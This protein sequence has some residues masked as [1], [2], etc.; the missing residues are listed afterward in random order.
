M[1]NAKVTEAVGKM[2]DKFKNAKSYDLL[3]ETNPLL[4]AGG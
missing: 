4:V 1:E 3:N 2:N